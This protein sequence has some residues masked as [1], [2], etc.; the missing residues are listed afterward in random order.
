[1][2][3][4]FLSNE[5]TLF[6]YT[7]LSATGLCVL[8]SAFSVRLK[9]IYKYHQMNWGLTT[10]VL[11]NIYIPILYIYKYIH[12]YIY[13]YLYIYIYIH[14]FSHPVQPTTN[15]FIFTSN[16]HFIRPTAAESGG[17]KPHNCLGSWFTFI[18]ILTLQLDL[19][20][21]L[22][23]STTSFSVFE[24]TLHQELFLPKVTLH[25]VFSHT[26]TYPANSSFLHFTITQ[27]ETEYKKSATE[28]V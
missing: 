4:L 9:L 27:L 3:F 26:A 6:P 24:M 1:M 20:G 17:M 23:L 8:G 2:C 14:A 12:I 28:T 15:P 22:M 18:Y 19:N 16:H 21:H 7:T 13:I 11:N 5:P 10:H 25:S